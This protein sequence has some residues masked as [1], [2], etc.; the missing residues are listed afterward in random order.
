MAGFPM[1]PACRAEYE[2]P[3]DRRFH[4]QP[5]C[6]PG[7]R[8][9]T[10]SCSTAAGEPVATDDPLA[11]FVAA[12]RAGQDRRPE[13]AGRLSPGLRR[14]Q[15]RAVARAAPPQ[16]PRRKAVRRH[17]ARTS[18][19]AEAL[20]EVRPAERELAAVAAPADRACCASG[21]PAAVAEEVAPRQPLARRH[22]A[23]HAA[24]P[25]P[26]AGGGRH[27]AGDDQRQPLRRADRLPGRRR[28]RTAG[29]HRRP[30][31]DPRPPDPRPLRRLGDA[32][33]RRRG[34]A[35]AALARLRPAADR[36]AGRVPAPDPG[37]GRAAQGDVRPGPRP[38][39]LSQPSPGRSRSLRGLPGV[40]AA[41]SPS[42]SNCSPF[43]R[44]CIAHDLHPD[45]ASTRYAR[46]SARRDGKS[47]F[48][49]FSTIMRTWPAAW[50]STG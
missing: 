41:T 45:Y 2:D 27:A 16:A 30:V 9:A 21:P 3:A 7:L 44:E 6:L 42:T 13:G 5:T 36:A 11:C 23:L 32:R 4:A 17:G 37:G 40:R 33:R 22:A 35:G 29:R 47:S 38:P 8:A 39:G 19:A 43:S 50:P 25:S 28:P 49:P 34:T 10:A 48:S 24:A 1:C 14:T 15:R 31:P 20:C 12:L 18:P 26:A 46:A